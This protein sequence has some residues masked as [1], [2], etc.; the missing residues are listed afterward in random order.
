MHDLG[1]FLSYVFVLQT[2][3]VYILFVIHDHDSFLNTICIHVFFTYGTFFNAVTH[4]FIR[5]QVF[6]ILIIYC[7]IQCQE[8]L[9]YYLH[10]F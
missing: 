1:S 7:F 4:I 6:M 2:Q 9:F 5:I 8:F 3:Y 10:F